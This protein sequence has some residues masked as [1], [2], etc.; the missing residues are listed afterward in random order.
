MI[1]FKITLAHQ[2][3]RLS[4]LNTSDILFS[5]LCSFNSKED[6]RCQREFKEVKGC[7]KDV[8]M[9]NEGNK[10]N[11]TYCFKNIQVCSNGF[12]G[13]FRLCFGDY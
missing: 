5:Q 6:L 8:S 13:V 9:F 11:S 12:S 1:G 4:K 10:G 7:I 2:V 3:Q